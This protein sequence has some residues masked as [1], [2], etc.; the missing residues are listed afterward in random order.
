MLVCD[1]QGRPLR[2]VGTHLDITDHKQREEH[3]RL[4]A[5][6]DRLTGLPNRALTFELAG[7][8]LAASKREGTMCAVLFLDLDGFKPINDSWGHHIGDEVLKEVAQR[9]RRSFRSHDVVGRLGGDEFLVVATQLGTE[10]DAVHA[11]SH[12]L[13]Q[14]S[15]PYHIGGLELHTSPSIGISLCPRD[16]TDIDVLVRRADAAM[17]EAKQSGKANYRFS[18]VRECFEP[19]LAELPLRLR[20]GMAREELQLHFQPMVDLHARRLVA[21]EALLR[22]P[23]ADGGTMP[24]A[25][26]IAVAEQNGFIGELGNW[27]FEHA[28]EQHR[29]WQQ[30]GLPPVSIGINLS[31]NQL[32]EAGLPE[33]IARLLQNGS[34]DPDKL[35]VEVNDRAFNGAPQ[36][37]MA[38]LQRLKALGVRVTLDDFGV[39]YMTLEQLS[40]LPLDRVK[41]DRSLIAALPADRSSIAVTEAAISFGRSLGIEVVAE[42]LES[43]Q[44]MG[45]LQQRQCHCMQGFHVAPPMTGP[46]FADWY[47]R[48]GLS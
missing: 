47:R 11:A 23:T 8:C 17:Y 12:A 26:C 43:E 10:L 30:L 5:Q 25:M 27:I 7:H 21:A 37:A 16:G 13:Q 29:A 41:I 22:W 45:F 6:H 46:Q 4:V 1:D 35:W 33:A 40:R 18:A 34:I 48:T 3:V 15:A 19:A 32:R 20:E 39:G 9:L 36:Y 31:A 14:L 24:P 2:M 44:V 42:G 38:S 28:C